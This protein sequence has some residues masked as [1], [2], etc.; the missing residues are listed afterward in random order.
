MKRRLTIPVCMHIV[1]AGVLI[2]YLRPANAAS[3]TPASGGQTAEA[4]LHSIYDRYTGPHD[5]APDIDYTKE[6][7][8]R[9]YFDP[10]LAKIIADD[11]ARAARNGDEGTLEA[12]PFIDAQDWEIKSFDIVVK[13]V[14][15]DHAGATVK[16]D[17]I[18][19]PELIR[20]QLVRV[21]GAWRIHDIDYGSKQGTLRSLFKRGSSGG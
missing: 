14:D 13:P 7:E 19:E 17:N 3:S 9:R 20:L 8:L 15:A 1:A 4:F 12:D 5:K 6:R 2:A 10:S 21:S 11:S 16:F 18:G